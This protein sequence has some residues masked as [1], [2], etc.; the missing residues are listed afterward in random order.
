VSVA[1]ATAWR[2]IAVCFPERI[3]TSDPYDLS[4]AF[5]H[6]PSHCD[7]ESAGRERPPWTVTGT[8]SSS[9]KGVAHAQNLS[10]ALAV[11]AKC[12]ADAMWR[13]GQGAP[14]RIWC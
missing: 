2:A 7:T 10:L 3:G 8:L 14:L 4:G 6:R 1:S 9:K 13:G 5:G 12:A 11:A